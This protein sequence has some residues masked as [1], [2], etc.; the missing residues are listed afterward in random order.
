MENITWDSLKSTEQRYLKNIEPY[1]QLIV[2]EFDTTLSE[3]SSS[4]SAVNIANKI[5]AQ[6]NMNVIPICLCLSMLVRL[7]RLRGLS[8]ARKVGYKRIGMIFENKEIVFGE[9]PLV[10]K[11]YFGRNNLP[12]TNSL[13]P[14]KRKNAIEKA[15]ENPTSLRKAINAKCFDCMCGSCNHGITRLIR[16]CNVSGCPLHPVRP[17]Q[18]DDSIDESLLLG[19][20][21]GE[22]SEQEFRAQEEAE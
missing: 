4:T 1:I 8:V 3:P 12:K 10:Q 2:R 6:V 19:G 20:F 13:I 15:K 5:S 18:N 9:A 21:N 22:S 11:T 7:G 16:E 17:Y 14:I